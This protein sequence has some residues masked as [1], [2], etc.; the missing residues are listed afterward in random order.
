MPDIRT[1]PEY[2]SRFAMTLYALGFIE[3]F[4]DDTCAG[5]RDTD[6]HP[7]VLDHGR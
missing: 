5:T 1:E 3:D 2:I 7:H 6:R 4:G